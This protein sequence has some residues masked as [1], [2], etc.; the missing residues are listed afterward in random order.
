MKNCM[1]RVFAATTTTATTT[2]MSAADQAVLKSDLTVLA[3]EIARNREIAGLHYPKD[4]EG[5]ARIA[6]LLD[7]AILIPNAVPMF[8][9]AIAAAVGEW[10]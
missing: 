3:D 6:D 5:G 4:S 1:L 2:A 10:Q 7:T 8:D 9:S